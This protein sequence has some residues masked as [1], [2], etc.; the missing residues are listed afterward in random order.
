MPDFGQRYLVSIGFNWTEV[1]LP[2]NAHYVL[3]STWNFSKG[4]SKQG[5]M[6]CVGQGQAYL[7][8]SFPELHMSS[9]LWD[10]PQESFGTWHLCPLP[11][12]SHVHFPFQMAAVMKSREHGA[13]VNMCGELGLEH[14]H[15]LGPACALELWLQTPD[16]IRKRKCITLHWWQ[17]TYLNCLKY[18]E[19]C[20]F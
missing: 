1:G 3:D 13:L 16:Y 2:L 20:L 6:Q 15:S 12:L 5:F 18:R 7:D 8:W 17:E 4:K 11:Q 14:M 19:W 10:T 9:H